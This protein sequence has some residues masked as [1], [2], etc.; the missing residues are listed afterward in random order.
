MSKFKIFGSN[1]KK[2][3]SVM[4]K[5]N[6][7]DFKNYA[8][9]KNKLIDASQKYKNKIRS[10]ENF[11]LCFSE[12]KEKKDIY[13]PSD[14]PS[15]SDNK[16]FL[17][18]KEK[19]AVRDIR[20]VTYKF[21]VE[22]VKKLPKWKKRENHE[23]LKEALDNCWENIQ[24][25]IISEVSLTKLEESKINYNKKMN[26]I[27]KNN[28]TLNKEEH[29]DVICNNCF[30]KDFKGKRFI[31]SECNNYNLCQECE[32]KIY[33]RQI[34]PREHTFIQV[35]KSLDDKNMDNLY[36][37]NNIIGNNNL[38][39]KN[40]P[41]SFQIEIPIINNGENDLN[42]CYILPV[43]YG[44]NYLTCIPKIIKEEIQRNM[45]VKVSLVVRLPHEDKGYFEGY[46]R[47]FS[48]NG[49]PFGNILIVKVLN[50]D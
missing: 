13:I 18:F 41:S 37:Y 49:L 8:E 35:N 20:D 19:L 7:N 32:K 38:E 27:N 3:K 40:M 33:Q 26:E 23:F 12:E 10:D 16:T 43:R 44:N 22:K 25:D 30:K 39:F 17:H 50:G 29:K 31:C 42:N 15:I 14:L 11:V 1:D 24:E 45:S 36:K 34:H 5:G 21:F 9:L 4:L 2:D 46:F 28:Q 48:P 6:I 47:M